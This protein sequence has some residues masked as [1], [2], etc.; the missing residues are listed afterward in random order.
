[1]DTVDIEFE[2][3]CRKR[4]ILAKI[5]KLKDKW[6]AIWESC[7]GNPDAEALA[8]RTK[9]HIQLMEAEAA[10]DFKDIERRIE[11]I[12]NRINEGNEEGVGSQEAD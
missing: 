3:E 9:L 7:A 4:K 10:D 5:E 2:Y 12:N 6:Q 8:V 11:A 1:M